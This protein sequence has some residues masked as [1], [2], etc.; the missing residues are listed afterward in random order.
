MGMYLR[1]YSLKVKKLAPIHQRREVI[2][3][4]AISFHKEISDILIKY[5]Y[6]PFIILKTHLLKVPKIT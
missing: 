5:R 1:L 3:I 6:A 4:S 2:E